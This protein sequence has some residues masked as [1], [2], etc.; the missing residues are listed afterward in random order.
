MGTRNGHGGARPGAGRKPKAL[1]HQATAA[2]VESKIAEALPEI[3]D[4]LI[5]SARGGDVAAARYLCDR[6]LGRVPALATVPAEDTR[7]PYTE[8]DAEA[9][10]ANAEIAVADAE[11]SRELSRLLAGLSRT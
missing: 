9:A 4:G 6:L 3:I 10:A 7:L 2:A 11:S 1:L 5:V 8:A